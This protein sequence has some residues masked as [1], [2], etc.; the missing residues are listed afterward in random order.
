[1]VIILVAADHTLAFILAI[2]C[3]WFLNKPQMHG[4]Y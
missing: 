1:M 3:I 2:A 4:L